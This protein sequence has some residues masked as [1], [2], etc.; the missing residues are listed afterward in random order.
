MTPHFLNRWIAL[1]LVPCLLFS[2]GEGLAAFGAPNAR[3][4]VRESDSAL[5]IDQALASPAAGATH[6]FR[7][8]LSR[9]GIVVTGL[10]AATA[11]ALT[12]HWDAAA[13]LKS[14]ALH[15]LTTLLIAPRPLLGAMGV[16][17]TL[18]LRGGNKAFWHDLEKA[19]TRIYEELEKEFPGIT[20]QYHRW[21]DLS[22]QDQEAF[23]T[24]IYGLRIQFFKDHRITGALAKG[25]APQFG[26]SYKQVFQVLFEQAQL[27]PLGFGPLWSTPELCE[28]SI[29]FALKRERPDLLAIYDRWDSLSAAERHDFQ[30]RVYELRN[31]DLAAWGLEHARK[32]PGMENSY[33]Q[34][35]CHFF[36]KAQLEPIGFEND[37][38]SPEAARESVLFHIRFEHP[39]LLT[40]Y[41]RWDHLT[42]DQRLLLRERFYRIRLKEFRKWGL[43]PALAYFGGTLGLTMQT[44]FPKAGLH[45]LGFGPRWR[46]DTERTESLR[47]LLE[48]HQRRLLWMYD[49]WASLSDVQHDLFR[50]QI[51]K[52]AR[53]HA[54]RWKLGSAIKYAEH[55]TS[56]AD[57]FRLVFPKADLDPM[58]FRLDVSTPESRRQ[59][60]T[61]LMQTARPDLLAE[62]ARWDTL[63]L[64]GQQAFRLRV[65][66][67]RGADVA[68]WGGAALG[69]HALALTDLFEKARLD[70]AM[71][72]RVRRQNQQTR[73]HWTEGFSQ[74]I[75][76][77]QQVIREHAP[78]IMD[79]Y[80]RFESLSRDEQ[81]ALRDEIYRLKRVQLEA[82]GA[83]NAFK[84]PEIHREAQEGS[85][86]VVL[87][88]EAFK[89]ADL[90]PFGF[91]PICAT[92]ELAK[93]S[94]RYVFHRKAPDLL[95]QYDRWDQLTEAEQEEFRLQ[96]YE[97]TQD[98]LV[99]WGLDGA[100]HRDVAEIFEGSYIRLLQ[101]VF[102]KAQLDTVGFE[103]RWDTP[104]WTEVS[105]SFVLSR[106]RPML[107][108]DYDRWHEL[109]NREKD[110]FRWQLYTLSADDLAAWDISAQ[111]MPEGQQMYALFSRAFP[112]A[113]LSPF[114]F[115]ADWS[116]EDAGLA[117][118]LVRLE[119]FR[120]ALLQDYAR[121][122]HLTELERQAFRTQVGQITAA[123]LGT[124]KLAGAMIRREPPQFGGPLPWLWSRIFPKAF[125]EPPPSRR[126]RNWSGGTPVSER[127]TGG[128]FTSLT[129]ESDTQEGSQTELLDALKSAL[130]SQ[131]G[132]I[133][134]RTFLEAL[135][136]LQSITDESVRQA[137]DP[138]GYGVDEGQVQTIMGALRRIRPPQDAPTYSLAL[139]V[140]IT[141]RQLE[142]FIRTYVQENHQPFVLWIGKYNS[143]GH[144]SGGIEGLYSFFPDNLDATFSELYAYLAKAHDFKGK[145]DPEG[146]IIPR[147]NMPAGPEAYQGLS[148]LIPTSD[149]RISASL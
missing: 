25:R 101:I 136:A 84:A 126:H 1:V 23:R 72:E 18:S 97:L 141:I 9:R 144:F 119:H 30:R 60:L 28:A 138:D 62:Y 76:N 56:V 86:L 77:V 113:D 51:Y 75:L 2:G 6:Y 94:V 42:E 103:P 123:L 135:L 66:Q 55:L 59:S 29:R 114:G 149:R 20:E 71:F 41:E 83:A 3:V 139:N 21:E 58:G 50:R 65:Y 27:D 33:Q 88:R 15:Q 91:G 124:W 100:L 31:T 34:V 111:Q 78:R 45:P 36:Q 95:R 16:F 140:G 69:S 143:T 98:D 40:D 81:E 92:P 89:K 44:L 8:S 57:L 53:T 116:S 105:M 48:N 128:L 147:T 19:R 26:G 108:R 107:V 93:E 4:S 67:V 39:D 127:P 120:P 145:D 125:P 104:E 110:D 117:S 7:S 73:F 79:A 70:P 130:E 85:P 90:S 37:F 52:L 129:R 115:E 46:N 148:I 118:V 22:P 49:H 137:I 142:N 82:W 14:V 61:F 63:S 99:E 43:V 12:D 10:V 109:S 13:W 74:T 96:M 5:L 122:E 11:L 68:E 133:Y 38:S 131:L 24:V 87:L 54:S 146:R 121:W 132:C 134:P 102:D 112:K 47:Y 64:D 32:L 35:F 106:H 17:L 80:D